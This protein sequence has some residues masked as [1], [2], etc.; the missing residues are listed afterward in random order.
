MLLSRFDGRDWDEIA[1]S[2]LSESSYCYIGMCRAGDGRRHYF[3][4]DIF[5]K[6]TLLFLFINKKWLLNVRVT[7]CDWMFVKKLCVIKFLQINL[8]S[9]HVFCDVFIIMRMDCCRHNIVWHEMTWQI[10][11]SEQ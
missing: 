5:D 9:A 8:S 11:I 10:C 2:G 7:V 4:L 1:G 3:L 6:Q